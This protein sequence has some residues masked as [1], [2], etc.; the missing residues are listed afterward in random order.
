MGLTRLFL[1][2]DFK[3]DG[4]A[5]KSCD[6]NGGGV[7]DR[8]EGA[9]EV[10]RSGDRDGADDSGGAGTG[11]GRGDDYARGGQ[12]R[13]RASRRPTGRVERGRDIA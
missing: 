6:R 12:A 7:G 2:V 1:E 10:G 13:R 5:M 8:G 11:A 9:T 3:L 4:A